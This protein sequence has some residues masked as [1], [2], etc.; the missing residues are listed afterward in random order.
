[1]EGQYRIVGGLGS[2][3]SMKMRAVFRYRRLPHIFEMRN[4]AVR[5]E[6]AHVRPSIIPMVRG[7]DD[8]D[9]MV[10]STPILYELETRHANGRSILPDN[11][12]DRFLAEL[13]EDF[14]DEWLTKAMFHY[15]WYYATDRSFSAFWI[16]T[17]QVA[18]PEASRSTRQAFANQISERQV[19]R[20]ALVGCTEANKPVIERSYERVLDAL[21]P[22]VGFGRFLFGTRPSIGDFGLFG[23]LKTLGDD[24]TPQW[25]MRQRAPTVCHWIRQTDDLSGIS[26]E[27]RDESAQIPEAVNALLQICGDSYLPFLAANS[28]AVAMDADSV[29]LEILGLPFSQP[30]FRYQAK[31]YSRLKSLYE[32]LPAPDKLKT[33]GVLEQ[34]GCLEWLQGNAA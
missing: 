5:E 6:V 14:G 19:S 32:N 33:D 27:W 20:M 24:P 21:E 31:C 30:P 9:W 12:G 4:G 15:R 25:L 8:A 13:I 11:A 16:A 17:D 29:D 10:D 26:G 3:Y 22:H 34:T 18:G 23:Q 7:A 28:K 1:M 2:P